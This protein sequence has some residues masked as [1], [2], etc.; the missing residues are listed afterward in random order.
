LGKDSLISKINNDYAISSQGG[1]TLFYGVHKALANLTSIATYPDNL[2]SVNVITF[3]D[4]LDN[5]SS[6]MD[7]LIEGEVFTTA[8]AYATYV[9]KQIDSRTIG[10]K[11]ITAYSVGIRGNDVQ[12]IPKFQSNLEKIASDEKAHELT[13]TE[14]EKVKDIFKD[15]AGTLE[16][17]YSITNFNMKTTKVSSGAKV[18]MTFET[19]EAP[20]AEVDSTRFIEGTVT[21]TRTSAGVTFTL[22]DITYGAGLSSITGKSLGSAEGAGPITGTPDGSEINFAFTN[23]TG[24]DPGYDDEADFNGYPVH[25]KQWTMEPEDPENPGTNVWQVNSEYKIVGAS[26]PQVVKRSV[27][28]YLVLDS[29]RSLNTTQIGEIRN[30]AIEFINSLYDPLN[31][32]DE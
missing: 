17:E 24:F 10:G 9:D 1:T 27:I 31:P 2:E 7:T 19:E 28:I 4:G 26:T 15:I 13:E 21:Q 30:A 18:R 23:M 5:G 14:W 25:A 12:D 20:N 29:S 11:P 16:T 32:S 22:S 8:D 3:T 6:G